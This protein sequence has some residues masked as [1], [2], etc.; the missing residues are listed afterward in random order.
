M[1]APV[2][3]TIRSYA[4][5][6]VGQAVNFQLTA[7]SLVGGGADTW[8]QTGLPNGLT[9]GATT[10]LITGTPTVAGV[11]VAQVSV[12]NSNGTSALQT[13]T[14]Q[15]LPGTAASGVGKRVW[16]DVLTGLVYETDPTVETSP[17]LA[18]FYGKYNDL[19]PYE[20]VLVS[21]NQLVD[22]GAVAA[23]GLKWTA[24]ELEPERVIAQVTSWVARGTGSAR[25]WYGVIDLTD[26]KIK[27]V[28]PDYEGDAE[29][30]FTA[31][32]EWELTHIASVATIGAVTVDAGTD[33]L[34]CNAHGLASGATVRMTSSSALPGGLSAEVLY[35]VQDVTTNTFKVALTVDGTAVDISSTGT[36]THTLYLAALCRR[37]SQTIP[38]VL[39]RDLT[40][41]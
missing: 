16:F 13:F 15:V 35:Y 23:T 37:S 36:G 38:F 25:V 5:A 40:A 22:V 32:T 12:T 8:T 14:V 2:I 24:K 30:K 26:K 19:L 9:I 31:I 3:S 21:G 20:V 17:K 27:G 29:T 11:S 41:N 39:P 18:V 1:A 6:R 7:T 4:G 10:G 34:T 28:L 33:V